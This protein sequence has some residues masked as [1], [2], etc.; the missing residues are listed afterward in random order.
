MKKQ[1]LLSVSLLVPAILLSACGASEPSAAEIFGAIQNS[2]AKH[3]FNS[4]DEF[5]TYFKKTGCDKA[6]E[7]TF[8]CGIAAKDGTGTVTTFSYVNV[9]GQWQLTE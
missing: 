3:L 2:P 1:S 4:Q 8:K 5:E 9:D 6:G 7:K